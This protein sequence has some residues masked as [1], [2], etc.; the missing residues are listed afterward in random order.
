MTKKDKKPYLS[1]LIKGG[2][3]GTQIINCPLFGT[4]MCLG[5]FAIMG[6]WMGEK[7]AFLLQSGRG[8]IMKSKRASSSRAI[9]RERAAEDIKMDSPKP[10]CV[11]TTPW[12]I[13]H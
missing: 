7:E 2:H 5:E 12:K 1:D 11:L 6:P 8:L 4:L 3:E 13:D 10:T 9:L